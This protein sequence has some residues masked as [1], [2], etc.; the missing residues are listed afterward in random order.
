MIVTI[1]L[2][3]YALL[4]LTFIAALAFAAAMPAPKKDRD[5]ELLQLLLRMELRSK[6]V[7]WH[8]DEAA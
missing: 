3:V 7:V 5:L 2:V 8:M 1:L 4:G 6:P